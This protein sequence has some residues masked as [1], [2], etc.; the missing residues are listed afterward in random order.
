M[1][2][3]ETLLFFTLIELAMMVRAWQQRVGDFVTY[4]F[5]PIF[6]TFTGL[7]ASIGGLEGAQAWEWCA[8]TLVLAT[9]GKFGGAH[10]GAR[11]PLGHLSATL[12]GVMMNARG[13]MELVVINVGFDLG[14]ISQQMFTILVL[15]ALVS[16]V[17]TTPVLRALLPRIGIAVPKLLRPAREARLPT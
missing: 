15:M 7:R 5:M 13:L 12:L 17:I 14:V 10:L 3:S 8:L 9:L 6:F 1:H 16:T 11:A 2:K 4:F